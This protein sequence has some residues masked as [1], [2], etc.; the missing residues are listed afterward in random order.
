MSDFLR[1][2]IVRVVFA[3]VLAVVL[4]GVLPGNRERVLHEQLLNA[5]PKLAE[6]F[7]DY[8]WMLSPDA[9]R[10]LQEAFVGAQSR[11]SDASAEGEGIVFRGAAT[12]SGYHLVAVR[13]SDERGEVLSPVTA[14]SLFP[15]VVAILVAIISGRLILGLSLSVLAGGFLAA[16]GEP[17][18]YLPILALQKSLIDYV[19]APL[20]SSFQLYI[21]AF[22][23]G[24][25]GMVRVTTLS[26]GNRGI[27]DVLS[28]RAEGARSTRLAAFFMGLAIF[29]DDYANSIVVGSTLRPIAD[30]FRVSREKLAYIVDSNRRPYCGYCDYQYVDW[31]RSQP[32]SGFDG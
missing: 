1:N 21:L 11:R 13:G 2:P 30:R 23:A 8:P 4:V 12:P 27:A 25:I 7:G 5:I 16:L 26:G 17:L 19:W 29:F 15:P 18:Y 9:D 22:T 24:L 10:V 14:W 28:R 6:Q 20:T 31:I 32:F 3:L